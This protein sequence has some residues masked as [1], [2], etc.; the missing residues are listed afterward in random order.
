[1]NFIEKY[2]VYKHV[3][4]I[5]NK[6]YI[7]ITKQLPQNRWGCNGINYKRSNPYFCN[8]I[9]KYGWD[10]FEHIIIAYNLSKDEACNLEIKL[11][12]RFKTQDKNYG[13]NILDGGTSPSLPLETRQKIAKALIGNKNGF[14][15]P[16][17]ESK[18]HK[19]SKAQKG[20]KLTEEHKM[21]LSK[22]KAG[23]THAFPSEET[24]KKISD[25]HDK[26]PIYCIETNTVYPSVQECARQLKLYATNICK[27]CKGKIKS[28]GGYHLQ[29]YNN[30]Q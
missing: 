6:Q 18:K 14:G 23:K 12:K 17:S 2:Y 10:N 11:I 1:M 22:A 3:N 28:T 19:I 21:K 9:K 20:R 8:A 5:N 25:S 4:K 13:Y 26:K 29:Y 27:C 15:H 7:G 16:C 24:K 30:T